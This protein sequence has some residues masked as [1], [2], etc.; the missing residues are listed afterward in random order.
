MSQTGERKG[1]ERKQKEKN[2]LVDHKEDK[3]HSLTLAFLI[4]VRRLQPLE[5]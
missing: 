2:E 4:H 1:K 3:E 5:A